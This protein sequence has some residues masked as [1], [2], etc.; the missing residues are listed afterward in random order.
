MAYPVTL[1][2]R[3]YTLADFEGTNYVEGLPDAFEDFVTHAGDIYNSTSTTSNSIGTGSKTFTVESAKPYQAG[4]PLRIADAAAPSTNFMD[5]IVTSYSGTT[6]VVDA[7]G[8]AGSGTFTSWNVNIGGAASVAGTLGIAQGGTGG[9]TAADARTNLDVYS[10]ADADSRFLNVSGEA[11]NVTMT[12]DVTIGD[13]STDTLTVAAT[14][15]FDTDTL[16]IDATNSR[17]GVGTTS[18]GRT[19]SIFENDQPVFQITNNTSGSG[20]TRGLIQYIPTGSTNA[21]F[22]NQGSG[23]GGTIQFMQAGIERLRLATSSFVANEGSADYDFRVESDTN[24]H[25]FFVD[26]GNSRVGVGTGSISDDF[27][28][29]NRFNVSENDGSSEVTLAGVTN[30]SASLFFKE[31]AT[32]RGRITAVSGSNSLVFSAGTSERLRMNDSEVVFNDAS[33]DVDFR[34]ESD[35]NTHLLYVDSTNNRVNIGINDVTSSAQMAM[36]GSLS[37]GRTSTTTGDF[38]SA[39]GGNSTSYNGVAI[40]SN[41]KSNSSQNN[42]ALNSWIVD[43]GGRAGDGVT[44]P[45]S[46]QNTFSVRYWGAGTAAYNAKNFLNIGA[47]S[48]VINDDS[49]DHDFRVE[50]DSQPHALFLDAGQNSVG[51]GRSSPNIVANTQTDT[52]LNVAGVL[53][54][55]GVLASHQSN[56]LILE[57]NA[58]ASK[59]RCYGAAAGDGTLQIQVGGGGGTADYE[60]ARF[61]QNNVVINELAMDTDFRVESDNNANALVVNA[62]DDIVGIGTSSGSYYRNG[63]VFNASA[64]IANSAIIGAG[65]VGIMSNPNGRVFT[66]NTGSN[67]AQGFIHFQGSHYNGYKDQYFWCVNFSGNWTVYSNTNATAGTPPTYTIN[68]NSSQNPSITLGFSTGYSGGYCKVFASVHWTVT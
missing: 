33:V 6:L 49:N 19:F 47:N 51:I 15:A 65:Y 11:S 44:F 58:N 53:S 26:A 55:H 17:V 67:G 32:Q 60:V 1:N 2:G 18:P 4:T 5:T 39:G 63:S 61:E 68:N 52:S 22:D 54:V 50:S 14:A 57:R 31:G 56:A 9:S 35:T 28:V 20:A 43:V 48:T 41:A 27:T 29:R 37:V 12:G 23:S 64:H 13:A 45:V 8:Y 34:V 40:M 36:Q 25:A 38:I 7:V 30:R 16:Y 66:L 24:T 21:V 3:T 10:K 46:T 59:I 62:G 42:T